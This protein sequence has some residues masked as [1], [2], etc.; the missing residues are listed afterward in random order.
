[1]RGIKNRIIL[2]VEIAKIRF[3]GLIPFVWEIRRSG[4]ANDG[5][6][7]ANDEEAIGCT[8]DERIAA[9]RIEDFYRPGDREN[10]AKIH[11]ETFP[12]FAFISCIYATYLYRRDILLLIYALKIGN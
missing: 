9:R 3:F 2:Q 12:K 5:G 4:P 7:P 10:P 8:A 6:K 1:M 11:P